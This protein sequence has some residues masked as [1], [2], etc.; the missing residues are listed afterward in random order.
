VRASLDLAGTLGHAPDLPLLIAGRTGLR[1][2]IS[3]V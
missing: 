2:G 1:E 3:I